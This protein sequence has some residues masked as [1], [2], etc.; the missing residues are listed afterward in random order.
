MNL[1]HPTLALIF[2][3]FLIALL[4]FTPLAKRFLKNRTFLLLR[5]FFP[6]WKFF[7][8]VFEMPTL[9]FRTRPAGESEFGPWVNCFSK[10]KR[11]PWMPLLNPEGNLLLAKYS[12]LQQ[13]QYDLEE[14][15]AGQ[16]STFVDSVSYRLTKALAEDTMTQKGIAKGSEFQFKVSVVE[17]TLVSITH[18]F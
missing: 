14:V 8:D 10:I 11:T 13:L 5:A 15:K 4:A 6:S 12:L 16:E 1:S 17:D 18:E 3:L 9:Y 2:G 7:E